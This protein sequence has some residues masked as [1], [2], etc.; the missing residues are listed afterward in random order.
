MVRICKKIA[1]CSKKTQFLPIMCVLCLLCANCAD[2]PPMQLSSS[3]YSVMKRH[4]VRHVASVWVS[5]QDFNVYLLPMLLL[6]NVVCLHV[7]CLPLGECQHARRAPS[8]FFGH[9]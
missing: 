4:M 5:R 9:F 7:C 1:N 3:G 6:L 2:T 8:I